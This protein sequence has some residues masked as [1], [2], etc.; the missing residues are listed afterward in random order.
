MAGSV[1]MAKKA[2]RSKMKTILA[3][4]SS[5]SK[6]TQ[7]QAVSSKLFQLPSYKSARSVAVYLS[8]EEEVGTNIILE[9]I[10]NTGKI[11]YIPKYHM[12]SHK[13]DMVRLV[14]W[15]DYM[16]LPVTKWNIKQPGE[17][18]IREEA[19]DSDEGLDLI[20][21]PGLA[22]T[23]TGARCGRGKGYYDTY[24]ARAKEKQGTAPLTVAL[25]FREQVLEEVPTDQHDFKIDHVLT[26]D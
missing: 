8:M 10:L 24:L 23:K 9:D 1:R 7:S 5:E 13:M 21:I 17:D 6:K 18:D 14:D 12:D 22:F 20:L 26:A 3:G 2:L 11:C 25:A 16:A 19:L 4:I 15:Q